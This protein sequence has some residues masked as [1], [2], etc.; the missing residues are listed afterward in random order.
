MPK[1]LTLVALAGL[2]E[3]ILSIGNKENTPARHPRKIGNAV[4][5]GSVY[6]LRSRT[7]R[8]CRIRNWHRNRRRRLRPAA[9]P[10]RRR[11]RRRGRRASA[12]AAAVSC[13]CGSGIA[14]AAWLLVSVRGGDEQTVATEK[15]LPPNRPT[16][17]VGW[18]LD[19][20]EIQSTTQLAWLGP[21]R[22]LKDRSASDQGLPP[23]FQDWPQMTRVHEGTHFSSAWCPRVFVY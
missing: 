6:L 16:E 23:Q 10:G 20:S 17:R 11:Q 2:S 1:S 14:E 15:S 9:P 18:W 4:A 19:E 22:R 3:R 8:R 13:R 7:R 5:S 12:V 21:L